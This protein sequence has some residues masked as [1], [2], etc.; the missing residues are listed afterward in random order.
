MAIDKCIDINERNPVYHVDNNVRHSE[1]WLIQ[2]KTF[3]T[4]E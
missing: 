1:I 3:L 2:N 4:S